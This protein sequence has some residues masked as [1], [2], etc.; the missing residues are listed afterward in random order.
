M[1]EVAPEQMEAS[2]HEEVEETEAEDDSWVEPT[3]ITVLLE[4]ESETSVTAD[5]PVESTALSLSYMEPV[6]TIMDF[7][8]KRKRMASEDR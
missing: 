3:S 6:A 7:M 5:T 1:N 4:R 2:R 8:R